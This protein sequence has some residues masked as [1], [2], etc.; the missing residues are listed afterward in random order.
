MDPRALVEHNQ[1]EVNDHEKRMN[2]FECASIPAHGEIGILQD[3]KNIVRVKV[4]QKKGAK[5]VTIIENIPLDVRE[6]VLCSLRKEMGCGG[7]LLDDRSIQLQ[8]DKTTSP[9]LVSSLKKYIKGCKVEM[10]GRIS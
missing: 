2:E 4:Q 5:K 3:E 10:N 1:C 6:N 7:T 9:G 8:G